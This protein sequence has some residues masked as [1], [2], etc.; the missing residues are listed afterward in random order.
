M[1][2]ERGCKNCGEEY[3]AR[4]GGCP[5]CSYAQKAIL[6]KLIRYDSVLLNKEEIED[7]LWLVEE[8]ATKFIDKQKDACAMAGIHCEE[9]YIE[10]EQSIL[11]ILKDV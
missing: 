6:K 5:V 3:D 1:S 4:H 7:I 8:L 9:E 11:D 10:K 2:L